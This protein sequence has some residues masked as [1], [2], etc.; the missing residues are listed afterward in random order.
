[1][2]EKD[3]NAAIPDL[4]DK[5]REK[6]ER[7]VAFRLDPNMRRRIDPSDVLQET[8]LRV[9]ER[10]AEFAQQ[11]QVC[12]FVWLRQKAIQTLIDLQRG[13]SRERRDIYREESIPM[14]NYN[15]T[16]SLSIANILIDD[17]TSPSLAAVRN[18][19]MIQLKLALDSMNEIDREVLAMR[20]FEHLNNLEVAQA[21]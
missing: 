20:H 14:P 10:F 4:L 9:A 15:Q 21:L 3:G 17:I 18:E 7:I 6:L 1:M 11:S 8:Y 5:Y 12:F 16:T 2:I 13:H 19:E